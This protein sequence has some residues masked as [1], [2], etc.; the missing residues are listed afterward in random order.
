MQVNCIANCVHVIFNDFK[1]ASEPQKQSS[2]YTIKMYTH[3]LFC[4]L[5]LQIFGTI[6]RVFIQDEDANDY[7][8]ILIFQPFKNP[9]GD[10]IS[11]IKS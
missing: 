9:S 4:M 11:A 5:S 7:R 1:C 3:T 8:A 10:S 6:T 2:N